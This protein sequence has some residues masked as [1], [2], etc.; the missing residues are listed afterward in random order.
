MRN[1]SKRVLEIRMILFFNNVNP[2]TRIFLPKNRK[3]VPFV[4]EPYANIPEKSNFYFARL[5]LSHTI[6]AVLDL[7]ISNSTKK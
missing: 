1:L 7:L 6:L 3:Y 4:C 2:H 5:S